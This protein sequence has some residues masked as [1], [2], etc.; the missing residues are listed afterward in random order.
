MTS[1]HAQ[2]TNADVQVK[3]IVEE[4]QKNLKKANSRKFRYKKKTQ[5]KYLE[6]VSTY[7]RK[8]GS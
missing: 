6:L 3:S 1:L 5:L 4:A 7:E 2:D 8:K